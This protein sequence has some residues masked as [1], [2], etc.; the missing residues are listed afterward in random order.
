MIGTSIKSRG[1]V[2]QLIPTEMTCLVAKVD[3]NWLWLKRF[4]HRNFDKI[5]KASSTL[6]VRD[7]PKI[8]KPTNIVYKEY[9][10]AK[11][12]KIYFPS[13]KFTTIE[14]LEFVYDARTT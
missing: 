10:M 2:F 11:H 13:N 3:N 4:C 12:K 6:R 5:V 1:N 7:L 9:V 14:K 8:V